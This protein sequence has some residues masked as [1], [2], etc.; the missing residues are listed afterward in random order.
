MK[1]LR[2]E[3]SPN[4]PKYIW[5]LYSST[6]MEP[7]LYELE[8]YREDLRSRKTGEELSL[9]LRLLQPIKGQLPEGFYSEVGSDFFVAA[10]VLFR[11]RKDFLASWMHYVFKPGEDWRM[12]FL[13]FTEARTTY[14]GLLGSYKS[15]VIENRRVIENLHTRE[16][17][18][19]PWDGNSILEGWDI[20]YKFL[21]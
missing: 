2:L 18:N 21:V 4:T 1:E 12:K 8:Y 5:H 16:C 17:S 7:M 10:Y 13:T 3:N 19:C 20:S 14:E 6:L 15:L 11:A 9:R